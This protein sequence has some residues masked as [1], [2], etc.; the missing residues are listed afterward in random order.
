M[1]V[2]LE[3]MKVKSCWEDGRRKSVPVSRCHRHKLPL[4]TMQQFYF[5]SRANILFKTK[6][7]FIEIFLITDNNLT[8]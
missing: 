6:M 1:D 8:I 2:G 4:E 7:Y 5:I 3:R